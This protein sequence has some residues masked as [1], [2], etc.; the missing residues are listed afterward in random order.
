MGDTELILVAALVA[1]AVATYVR[2]PPL[3]GFLVAG[4]VLAPMGVEST[5][6]LETIADLGVT[7][8]LFGVGL[9]M[10]V[11]SLL[12]REVFAVA[13]VHTA[14]FMLIGAGVIG[15]LAVAG[16]GAA[17]HL[18]PTGWAL[19]GFATSFS[20]T[21]LVVKLLEERNATRS[22]SGRTAIGV[23]VVQ[24]LAAV[25][26]LAL[27]EGRVPSPWAVALL[28]LVPASWLMRGGLARLGHDELL[29]LYG[30]VLALVPGYWLFDTLNVKGDLGALIIGML[31]ASSPRAGELAKS[32]FTIKDLLLVGFFI[33]IGLGGLPTPSELLVVAVLLLLLPLQAVAFTFLFWLCRFRL[34]TSVLTATALTN[35]SEFGLIVVVAAEGIAGEEWVTILGATVAAGMVIGSL[36][37]DRGERIV[38]MLRGLLPEHAPHRLHPED[39]PLDAAGRQAVVLGMGRVGRSAY[40]RLV[41]VYGLRVLGIETDRERCDFLRSRGYDVVE[42]DATDPV[43]W[44]AES[45]RD[46]RLVLLAMPFH[47]SNLIVLERLREAGYEGTVA[48]VAQYDDELEQARVRGADAGFQLYDGAGAELADRAVSAADLD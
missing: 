12:R 1:G 10:D 24:D 7:V 18:D 21:V 43:L 30:V 16:V 28:A 44:S 4:F 17:A 33:S 11:R 31:L 9:K 2:L 38:R 47:Q 19:I 48:V 23:L 41:D 27:A 22:L 25:V 36:P 37:V 40:S 3:V 29:P 39:R 13:T 34:R 6:T 46:T 32:L 42:G 26:F 14:T 20:S 5:P 45:F 15:L 35:F 8:L